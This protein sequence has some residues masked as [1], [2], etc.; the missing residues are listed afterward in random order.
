MIGEG[1]GFTVES[2]IAVN[3]GCICK[4]GD[5]GCGAKDL[6]MADVPRE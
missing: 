6:V 2:A 1:I 4:T 3:T 5:I